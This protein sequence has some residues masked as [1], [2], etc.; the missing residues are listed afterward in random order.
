MVLSWPPGSESLGGLC[1]VAHAAYS[2][3]VHP[4]VSP[5]HTRGVHGQPSSGKGPAPPQEN[6]YQPTVP[7][8]LVACRMNGPTGIVRHLGETKNIE[9]PR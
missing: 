5:G 1:R 4:K 9:E 6:Q 3:P 8:T 7:T 2:L